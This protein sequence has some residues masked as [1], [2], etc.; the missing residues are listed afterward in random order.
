MA[1]LTLSSEDRVTV[2]DD[3]NDEN[4]D[5]D[6]PQLST[7]ALA[8]LQEFLQERQAQ[9]EMEAVDEAETTDDHQ[10]QQQPQQQQELRHVSED[11]QLSQF[12]YTES[13]ALALAREALAAAGDGGRIACV[14]CPT[15]YKA[16]VDTLN[17]EAAVEAAAA[18]SDLSSASSPSLPPRAVVLEFDR[19]FAKWGRDFVFYDYQD[20][21]VPD[22]PVE[23][24]GAF[25]VVVCDPPFL[26][27]PCAGATWRAAVDTLG[28]KP[29]AQA[30]ASAAAQASA[31]VAPKIMFCTGEI[32]EETLTA[33]SGGSLRKCETFVPEHAS[34]LSNPFVLMT[35]FETTTL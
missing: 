4:D 34:K 18:A 28:K 20:P 30:A 6:I 22:L 8:A 15:L 13:T 12:W 2:K 10:Q 11:W 24:R 29:A 31:S 25:D 27:E 33:L 14:S 21:S 5:D 35:N 16:V 7:N 17:K 26:T 1:S 23:W 9:Q 3:E 19:R 32:M